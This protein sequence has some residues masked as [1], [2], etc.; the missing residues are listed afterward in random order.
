LHK[1][2]TYLSFVKIFTTIQTYIEKHRLPKP[3]VTPIEHYH[4]FVTKVGKQIVEIM[5][6]RL[7]LHIAKTWLSENQVSK[8]NEFLNS[9]RLKAKECLLPPVPKPWKNLFIARVQTLKSVKSDPF[10]PST[11]DDESLALAQSTFRMQHAAIEIY[12]NYKFD[13]AEQQLSFFLDLFVANLIYIEFIQNDKKYL[14]YN[15]WKMRLT[16]EPKKRN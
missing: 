7:Y 15:T 6:D 13:D 10:D 16:M 8:T 5:T 14:A 1:N 2:A 11:Y 4:E 12:I 9:L 3:T